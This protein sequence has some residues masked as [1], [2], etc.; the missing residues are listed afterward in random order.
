MST[1]EDGTSAAG[2]DR[3]STGSVVGRDGL[4]PNVDE[5]AV[6]WETVTHAGA[7]ITLPNSGVCLTVPEGAVRKGYVEEMYLAVLRDDKDRPRLSEAQTMLSP[8]LVFGPPS[9]V[10]SKPVI[11]SFQHCTS[12][13]H[14]H[15]SLSIY[16]ADTSTGE[17][18]KWQLMSTVGQ[19]TINTPVYVQI[20]S[21]RCHVMT[22]LPMRY[23]LIGEPFPAG[24]KAVKLL[25]VAAFA[26]TL[27]TAPDYNL[28][29]YCVEDTVDALQSVIRVENRLGGQLL[30][31]P[32]QICFQFGSSSLCLAVEDLGPGWRCKVPDNYQEIPFRHVWSGTQN[33][34]HCSFALERTERTQ[35][36]LACEVHVFQQPMLA[37]RQ[38]LQISSSL[39]STVPS[40][41]KG[42]PSRHVATAATCHPTTVDATGHVSLSLKSDYEQTFRLPAL[43]KRQLCSLLDP[44]TNRGND[45]RMLAQRLSVDRYI[46][47]FATRSSPMEHIL[48]LWEARTRPTTDDSGN[49]TDDSSL[50]GAAAVNDL[51]NSLR[52]MGRMDAAAVIENYLQNP[53]L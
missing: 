49:D 2:R 6:V 35:F 44:P 30:T 1:A 39:K 33:G 28:R 4:P 23:S 18:P 41:A 31:K 51:L 50:S 46:N 21:T 34:L 16:G 5:D 42:T 12:V 14:G 9:I 43:V 25:R 20:D 15:W 22:D 40:P 13:K 26:P 11:L 52:V 29:V 36:L 24:A 38:L 47:Y 8:V 3:W 48:D 10:L 17:P 32:K 27:A 53:W 45:W 37:N 19:E 7:R